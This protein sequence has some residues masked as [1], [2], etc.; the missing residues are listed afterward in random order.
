MAL[1]LQ[2]VFKDRIWGGHALKAFNYDI[3]NETTGECWAIS[4]HPNGPNTIIN[5]PYKDMTL[6]QLWSQHRELFDNDSRDSFPL[7]T[8]V[9]DANDKLSVQVHPDDY[10]A[11]KHEGELG[12]T[13]CW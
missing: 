8:K 5:G 9:L 12:K 7:L 3:P 13:E 2:P 11:L 4:A 6:D 1:F 10:Y